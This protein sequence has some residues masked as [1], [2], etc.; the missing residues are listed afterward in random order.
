MDDVIFYV[1]N[2]K[3]STKNLL[4]L[5]VS[6]YN[7]KNKKYLHCKTNNNQKEIKTIVFTKD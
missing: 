6:G 7:V 5:K 3:D 2:P 1:E 4:E